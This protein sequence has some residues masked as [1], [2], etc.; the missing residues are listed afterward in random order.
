[1][2]ALTSSEAQ[3]RAALVTVSSYDVFLDFSA[4]VATSRTVVRFGCASP[5]AATFADLR[6]PAVRHAALNGSETGQPADGRLPLPELAA[7]NV[8]S[9]EA[10]LSPGVLTRFTDP[11]DSAVYALAYAYPANAPELFCCFD[12]PGTPAP[13]TLTVRVPAGWT[14]VSNGPVASRP[15][16]GGEW[17][18]AP[19]RMN[20]MDFAL[21]AGPFTA[22]P[23]PGARVP[24]ALYGRAALSA[25]MAQC[26]GRFAE[27][28]RLSADRYERD[29][30]VP[31]AYAKYDVVAM[32]DIQARAACF[33]GVIIVSEDALPGLADPDD[34]FAG[35][36]A[37]HET[38]HWWFGGVARMSWW[39]DLWQEES[40]ATYVSY[41]SDADWAGFAWLEKPRAYRADELPSAQPVSSPVATMAQALDRPNAITYVKGTAVVRQLAGLIGSPAVTAGL[42]DYLTRYAARGF[43]TLDDLVA[44]WSRASGRDLSGWA[45]AWL[46]TTG[47]PALRA[48][49]T[50]AADGTIGSLRVAADRPW[51]LRV[52]V[53]LYDFAGSALVR[54]RSVTVELPGSDAVV[55]EF[56]GEPMPD[57]VIV[58]DD[59]RAFAHVMLDERTL[60]ALSSVAFT[61]AAPLAE[62]VCWNS[63]WHM[64]L[65][66]E[67][68]A[69][70]FAALAAGRIPG[71]E[72][73]PTAARVLLERA[74]TC[75]G[76]YVPPAARASIR[77][78]IAGAA[79]AATRDA[80][81]P[82]LLRILRAGFAASAESAEQ[83]AVLREWLDSDEAGADLTLRGAI[84][85]TLSARGLASDADL[86]TLTTADPVAGETL[87]ATCAAARPD[88]TAKEAAWTA[89]LATESTA[90]MARAHAE[91]FW[92]AGQEDL[93]AGYRDRYFG[94][95]LPALAVRDA[96]GDRLARR[97]ARLLFP[98][99]L[100]GEE[101]LTAARLA[102]GSGTVTGHL[103][104]VLLESEAELR[105]AV[106]ARAVPPRLR[107][108]S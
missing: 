104:D 52:S 60:A 64:V 50:P 92:V 17:R 28:V 102:L 3:A 29:F 19:V 53:G 89:A 105:T 84:L 72:L 45:D 21:C 20:P 57:A 24:A 23:L 48:V 43:A 85:R 12:Q 34:D 103:R 46:R 56:T 96:D 75:A 18:F 37:A 58:N 68:A 83:L 99:T 94:E 59:D 82:P 10:E 25:D 71:G 14:C 36:I 9:V 44:S 106:T 26:L 55:A 16:A 91:G 79:L 107:P 73:S 6:T 2:P 8:L 80:A 42:A 1:M 77:E 61:V 5:G 41:Q 98:S 33:P 100:A 78:M 54:R 69:A 66:G 76:L 38:A 49:L 39:D 13:L 30:Q 7:E 51:P 108:A 88:L 93:L 87:R 65:S 27:I 95:A 90:R 31:Y 4:P 101:T 97:L 40:L 62:A 74:V 63:V 32:P 86:D 22:T 70:D 47:T 67:F 15:A 35:M 81:A 11:A